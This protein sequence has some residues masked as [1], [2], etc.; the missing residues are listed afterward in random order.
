[1]SDAVM[2]LRALEG[3]VEL[4][5]VLAGLRAIAASV[6]GEDQDYAGEIR[7]LVIAQAEEHGIT[8]HRRQTLRLGELG[9]GA[10]EERFAHSIDLIMENIEDARTDARA[11]R[12]VLVEVRIKPEDDRCEL[13]LQATVKTKL[14]PRRDVATVAFFGRSVDG[15]L[16]IGEN[17]R[18]S[19]MR[20]PEMGE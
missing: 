5:H 12:K 19:Q 10:I 1:M 16:V 2:L 11:V 8:A 17:D 9:D 3:L 18:P 4:E 7:E 20:L 15:E 13:E 14:A 6:A